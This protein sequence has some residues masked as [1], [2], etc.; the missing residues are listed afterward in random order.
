MKIPEPAARPTPGLNRP[1]APDASRRAAASA[2][3]SNAAPAASADPAA[4]VELSDR[5]RELHDALRVAKA[6]PDVRTEVVDDVRRRLADGRYELN[7]EATA[8]RMIDR[9]A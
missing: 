8:R 3:G 1:S 2:A 4:T 7:A 5:A 6:A 9:R